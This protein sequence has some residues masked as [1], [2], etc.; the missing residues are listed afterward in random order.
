MTRVRVVRRLAGLVLLALLL[1]VP[2]A[3]AAPGVQPTVVSTDA[4]P[5]TSLD[6]TKTVTTEEIPPNPDIVFLADT[7][8]SMGGAIGNV[9]A[10]INDIIADVEAS[11]PT[12]Q[13]GVAEYRDREHCAGDPF[14]VRLDQ[15]VT[16]EP[17][18]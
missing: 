2:S 9:K 3:F 17:R 1:A 5:G 18:S 13:F 16:D 8:G 14:D 10:N 4:D 15:A 6:V 11:Q 7:T 12:A